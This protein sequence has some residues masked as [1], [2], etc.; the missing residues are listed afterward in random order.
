MPHEYNAIMWA[1]KI[2]YTSSDIND[3]IRYGY[4]DEK[5]LPDFVL[6]LGKTQDE[7]DFRVLEALIKES[8][9][10]GVVQLTEGQIA[11]DFIKAREFM[12]REVYFQIQNQINKDILRG[13]YDFFKHEPYFQDNQIDPLVALVLLTD[14]ECNQMGIMMMGSKRFTLDDLKK[15]SIFQ[16]LH[17]YAGKR[18]DF[19][20]PDLD[21]GRDRVAKKI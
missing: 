14:E 7:R 8:K 13:I 11:E 18:V 19:T 2:T 1:D 10:T 5:K 12:F 3:S 4:L 15:F 6:R 20:N 21:W 17:V 9:R 16:Y